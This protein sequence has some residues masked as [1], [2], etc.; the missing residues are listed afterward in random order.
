MMLSIEAWFS[1]KSLIHSLTLRVII[2]LMMTLILSSCT[3]GGATPTPRALPTLFPSPT[4]PGLSL[5]NA[6][7]VANIFLDAWQQRDFETMHRHI[8]FA[9]R[10]ASPFE[11][12]RTLYERIHETMTLDTMTYRG[13]TIGRSEAS[14]RVVYFTY[15]VT[16]QTRLVG[17]F[18]E[19]G[20]N[21]PLIYDDIDG[22]WRVA[23][24]SGAI[25]PELD[26]GGDL[27][28]ETTQA[29]RANI[30]D[31]NGIVLAAQNE[32]GIVTVNIVR[33]EISDPETCMNLL[34][35]ATDL[36]IDVIRARFNTFAADWVNEIGTMEPQAYVQWQ[37]QLVSVCEATFGN[38]PSRVYPNGNL[39]AHIIGSVGYPEEAEL[40]ELISQGF[41]QDSILGRNGIEGSWDEVLRGT[42]GTRLVIQT[43]GEGGR[44]I[45][46]RPSE[47][48]Q[49]VWLTID[50]KFQQQVLD[51][52]TEAYARNADTWG[53]VS[54]GAAA[55]VIDV[56][57][58]EILASVSYPTF[59][60]NA[61]VPF[62]SI[63][64]QAAQD[65]VRKTQEDERRPL[66]NRVTQGT[67]PTGSVMKIATSMAAAASGAVNPLTR[68]TCFGNGTFNRD[69]ARRDWLAAGHGVIN[70]AGAITQSCNP[71]FYEAGYQMDLLDPWTFPNYLNQFGLG[72]A[73]G[74]E[75]VAESVGLIGNPDWKRENRGLPWTFSDAVD[76]SIG[77]GLVEITPLQLVR[78]I[79]AVAN[80]GTLYEPRLVKKAGLLNEFTYMAEPEINGELGI[81]TDVLAIIREGMCDVTTKQW[82][83]AEFIFNDSPLQGRIGVCGKT[84]TAEDTPR[85]SHAWFGAYAPRD[86]PQIAVIV[87]VENAGEGSAVAAPLARDILEY[88][89][90]GENAPNAIQ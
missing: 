33:R 38:R 89:F 20:R 10:E 15:D 62:P 14:P 28:L 73:T 2:V 71:Y 1:L 85:T 81:G 3:T 24:T 8:S 25:F 7:R 63:G 4:P 31:R 82:G 29:N 23:W 52:L 51:L 35:E 22:D 27:R 46:N 50:T 17:E 40:P 86:K 41:R 80:G 90:F 16:F 12:F 48:A 56:N 53:K 36:P 49:S 58:G 83:T 61:F 21:L 88:Y 5:E 30:Y 72:R 13:V 57:T 37:E 84:G 43:P 45:A 78:M 65:I 70:M 34:S 26:R 9:S 32:R 66:L 67:Y 47:A 68:F 64:R 55:I 6:E 74:I 19:S 79:A 75:D 77:Q 39:M 60:A 59:D 76:M 44:T 69:I 42:P 54:R 87:I 11:T 18:S